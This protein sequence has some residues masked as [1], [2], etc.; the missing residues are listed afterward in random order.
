[1]IDLLVGFLYVVFVLC[2]LLLIV[3]ILLQEAK[4]GGL[5]GA[6]GGAGTE[7][8][9]VKAGG[10]NK[11]TAT[12]AAIFL[13]AAMIIAMITVSARSVVQSATPVE[14]PA[15]T[16]PVDGTPA[17]G[18]G[19]AGTTPPGDAAAGTPPAAGAEKPAE[20]TGTGE[21]PEKKE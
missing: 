10:I 12:V 21:A 14:A 8:F 1:V 9:G 6:F 13:G 18:A 15:D 3:I 16:V 20:G 19:N 17:D 2:A 4:G 11:F 7:A 5:A